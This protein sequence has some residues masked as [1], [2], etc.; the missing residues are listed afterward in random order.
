[1]ILADSRFAPQVGQHCR[2]PKCDARVIWCYT[3]GK[4]QMLVNAEPVVYKPGQEYGNI[5]LAD[6]NTDLP[7]ALVLKG[8]DLFGRQGTLHHA[9]FVTCPDAQRFRRRGYER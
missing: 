6:T 9:H 5:K 2:S 7:M 3:E 8:R 4:K 1:M